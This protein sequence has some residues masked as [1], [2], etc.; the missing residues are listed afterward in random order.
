MRVGGF[1][2]SF[3]SAVMRGKEISP[4]PPTPP[5]PT[6]PSPFLNKKAQST[7]Y[8]WLVINKNY[9]KSKGIEKFI[10]KWKYD[11]VKTKKHRRSLYPTLATL[12]KDV[13][14]Q[15]WRSTIGLANVHRRPFHWLVKERRLFFNFLYWDW[16]FN[17]K[18]FFG[19]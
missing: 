6:P 3:K 5:P 2:S 13:I 18:Y 7:L 4:P 9:L 8:L 1:I 12:F 16:E 14:V 15:K 19:N 10:E 11:L 17:T